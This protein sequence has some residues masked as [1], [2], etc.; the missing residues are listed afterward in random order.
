MNKRGQTS[1][2]LVIAVGYVTIVALFFLYNYFEATNST[3]PLVWTKLNTLKVLSD[4]NNFHFIRTLDYNITP[5][6]TFNERICLGYTPS[7][8]PS[9]V[10][11]ELEPSLK[12]KIEDPATGFANEIKNISAYNTVTV[13]V[14]ENDACT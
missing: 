4:S 13:N 10:N 14:Y 1:I 11:P 8:P 9:T 5:D 12:Q 2:E 7:T 3:L 6:G